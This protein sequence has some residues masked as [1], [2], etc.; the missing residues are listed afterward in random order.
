MP[1][2]DT[3]L[4]FSEDQDLAQSAGSYASTNYIDL[5]AVGTPKGA[6]AAIG[7]DIAFGEPVPIDVFI[8]EDF[9]SG[10]AA[11]LTIE[12]QVDDNTSFSSPTT[13][14]TTETIALADLVAGYQLPPM[15]LP[16][17]INER[18]AR[19]NYTVGTTSFTAGQITAGITGGRQTNR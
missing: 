8:T 7:R 15:Y 17:G 4:L 5:G 10:G 2:L 11:T 1:I 16:E 3:E 9:A 6:A 18:Y 14:Y 13:V 12:L 19:L